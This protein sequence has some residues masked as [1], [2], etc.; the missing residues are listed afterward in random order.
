MSFA[1]GQG[2]AR[3]EP[4]K[5]VTRRQQRAPEITDRVA[6]LRMMPGT[7]SI[8]PERGDVGPPCPCRA[9]L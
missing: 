5:L 7:G 6:R 1:A 2:R 9:C 3:Y 4:A 8:H